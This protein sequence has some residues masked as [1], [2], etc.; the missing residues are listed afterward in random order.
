MYDMRFLL[1]AQAGSGQDCLLSYTVIVAVVSDQQ[2]RNTI[3]LLVHRQVFDPQ[4]LGVDQGDRLFPMGVILI[5][6]HP[7]NIVQQ[8]E[9]DQDPLICGAQG[10]VSVIEVDKGEQQDPEDMLQP[11]E[12]ED[13]LLLV[14]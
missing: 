5:I 14:T 7:T 3:F 12:V 9:V 10:I 8:A 1:L 6:V 13:I 4:V 2:L 11:V